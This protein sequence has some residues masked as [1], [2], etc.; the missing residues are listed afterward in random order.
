M[1]QALAAGARGTAAS[2]RSQMTGPK[3]QTKPFARLAAAFREQ[4][5]NGRHKSKNLAG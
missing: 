2:R 4:R 5:L 3:P 1:P